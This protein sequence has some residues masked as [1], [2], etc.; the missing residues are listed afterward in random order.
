V[1]GVEQRKLALSTGRLILSALV[2]L[3]DAELVKI[4]NDPASVPAPPETR[5]G[6]SG[7]RHA[8][9]KSALVCPKCGLGVYRARNAGD[10]ENPKRCVRICDE[11]GY[12]AG[13]DPTVNTKAHRLAL[14][15]AIGERLKKEHE[16]AIQS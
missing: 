5:R 10:K 1:N 4:S 6:R 3:I 16:E 13:T 11:C 2:D 8:V 9:P 12:R 15:V 7:C 14:V